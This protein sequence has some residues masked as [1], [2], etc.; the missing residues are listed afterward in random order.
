ML[1]VK[2]LQNFYQ[3]VNAIKLFTQ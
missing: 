3:E 2:Y 1:K